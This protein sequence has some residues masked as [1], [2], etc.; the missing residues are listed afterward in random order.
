MIRYICKR[1]LEAIPVLLIVATLTFFLTRIAPGGPFDQERNLPPEIEK[2]LNQYYGFDQSL[3]K[4]Y[5]D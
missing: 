4:Q 5:F 2:Q 3:Y 1:L